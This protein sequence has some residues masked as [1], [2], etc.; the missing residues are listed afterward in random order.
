MFHVSSIRGGG[1]PVA[2]LAAGAFVLAGCDS[3][4]T[5]PDNGLEPGQASFTI[6][7][8]D[9]PAEVAD[10]WVEIADVRLVGQG[11]PISLLEE[12]TGMVNLLDLHGTSMVLVDESEVEAGTYSQLR[13]VLSGAVLE[14]MDGSVYAWGD[15]EHPEGLPTTGTLHCPSCAQSGLKVSFAG[16]LVLEE[17]PNAAWVDFDVSQSFGRQAGQSGRWVMR[18]V[19]QGFMTDPVSPEPEMGAIAGTVVLALDDENEPIQ[20]PACG[21][22]DRGVADFI[23]VA[24][25]SAWVDD[26]GEPFTFTGTVNATGAFSIAV[27][28]DDTYT[29]GHQGVIVLEEEELTWTATVAPG[30]VEVAG[31]ATVEGVVY[32]ITGASCATGG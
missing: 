29:L 23:P 13:F 17:G 1:V 31:G 11:Q 21:G 9:A 14:T 10:V 7:L 28:G 24:S 16:G 26:E 6:H 32:T 5:G 19:I 12:S 4:T 22:E 20:I 8:T 3:T 30:T 25:G 27:L 18:P 2:L 15:V